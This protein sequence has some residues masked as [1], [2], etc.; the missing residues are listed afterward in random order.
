MTSKE[1]ILDNPN[2]TKE[3]IINELIEWRQRA[4]EYQRQLII[5]GKQLAEIR[6]EKEKLRAE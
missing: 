6:H 1:W 2:V 4:K 3:Q 5:A